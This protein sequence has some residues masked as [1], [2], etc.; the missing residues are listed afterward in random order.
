MAYSEFAIF[1]RCTLSALA[2]L[3][4]KRLV[5]SKGRRTRLLAKRAQSQRRVG[6]LTWVTACLLHSCW[7]ME[8]VQAKWHQGWAARRC[9]LVPLT[10]LWL[11]RSGVHST[12]SRLLCKLLLLP[13]THT[14]TH[15]SER[16]AA[17]T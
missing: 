2:R 13:H 10:L 15:R 11:P 5:F 17:P 7:M 8:V 4:R 14:H 1:K 12:N 9:C 6:A 16:S 3:Q